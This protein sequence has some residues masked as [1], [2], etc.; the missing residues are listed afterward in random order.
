MKKLIMGSCVLGLLL[1]CG[2]TLADSEKDYMIINGEELVLKDW[3]F[4]VKLKSG[5][6]PE[7]SGVVVGPKAILTTAHCG[8]QGAAVTITLADAGTITGKLERSSLYPVKDHDVAIIVLDSAVDKAKVGVYAMVSGTATVGNE[9]YLMGYGCTE[10]GGGTGSDG[11]LRGGKSAIKSFSGFDMISSTP[12]GAAVCFGDSG[13][14][15]L[16][17]KDNKA[18]KVLGLNS[19]G[20]IRDT[21]YSV[22]MDIPETQ[23]FLKGVAQKAGI[24]ICGINGSAATCGSGPGP[25]PTPDPTPDPEPQPQICDLKER[26]TLVKLIEECL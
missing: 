16:L 15:V 8:A 19:K 1:L 17:S 26:A 21:N 11:K 13:G 20:N 5:E 18:P 6:S 25:D 23:D 14:P 3:G 2:F 10:A 12:G 22:R 9:I 4:A 24:E 7:C